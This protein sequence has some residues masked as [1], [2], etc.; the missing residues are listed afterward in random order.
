[1]VIDIDF[2]LGLLHHADVGDVA[3]ASAAHVASNFWFED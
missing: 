2:V 3:N 1:L